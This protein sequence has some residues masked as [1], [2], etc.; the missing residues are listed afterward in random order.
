MRFKEMKRPL[1]LLERR[2]GAIHIEAGH[3]GLSITNARYND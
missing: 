3:A 1:L 2:E